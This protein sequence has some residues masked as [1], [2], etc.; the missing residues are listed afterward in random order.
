MDQEF[1]NA[2]KMR[3]TILVCIVLIMVTFAVYWQ[4]G[5]HEFLTYDDN[6][7]IAENAHVSKG[8]TYDNIIW[9]FTSVD[10]C[11]WHPVTWLSHMLDTQI[12]GMNPRGHH[13]TNVVIHCCSTIF[14]FFLLVRLTGGLWQSSFVAAMFALHPLHVESVAWAAE[15]KDVLSACFGFLTLFLYSHYVEKQRSNA[16]SCGTIY[17]LTLFSFVLGLMSKPML[18]TLPVVMLLLDFWPLHRFGIGQNSSRTSIYSLVKEKI[19]FFTFSILSS[20]ITIYA[21]R[22]GGAMATLEVVPFAIRLQ[23]SLVS[24]LSYLLNTLWP[25]DLAVLYPYTLSIPLWQVISSVVVLFLIS[26]AAIWA[27]RRYPYLP[28]GWFWFLVTLLPVIGII[29]VG[30]QSMADRY[31]YI[32]SVGLF[33]MIAWGVPA[34][35]RTKRSMER[36]DCARQ[37]NTQRLKTYREFIPALLAAVTILTAIAVTWHQ[38]GY[39]KN[40][41]SLYQHTLKVTTGNYII[42]YNLGIAYGRAG[43]RDAA[44]KEFQ[45]AI[46]IKPS[47]SKVR[48]LLGSTLAEM[49]DLDG[50]ITEFKK[51]LSINPKDS[52]ARYS[53][54]FWLGQKEK[55]DQLHH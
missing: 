25:H 38:I 52:D 4:V 34:L 45:T 36:I 3:T 13:L 51:S 44:I 33:I 48:N 14:L 6:S 9:A 20:A 53:L 23:N 55:R 37:C 7:Y 1:E 46:M 40:N 28:V 19:P 43:D 5:N 26:A 50:A 16:K 30:F 22:K 41:F 15:R 35:F 29:Q 54:E 8:M 49:G 39:W 27:G 47:E 31:A 12:Y 17:L 32:P 24:Y 18:V 21:Q 42:N 11:N 2:V 10:Q